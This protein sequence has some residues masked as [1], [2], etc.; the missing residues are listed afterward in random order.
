MRFEH[1]KN[2]LSKIMGE[3]RLSGSATA[4]NAKISHT[5][6]RA[7]YYEEADLINNLKTPQ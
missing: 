6:I 3:Q 5:I 2:N 4:K 1:K 7:I